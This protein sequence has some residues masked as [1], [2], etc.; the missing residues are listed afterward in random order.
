MGIHEQTAKELFG[1]DSP[2][3][4]QRSVA[5][6]VNYGLLFGGSSFPVMPIGEE[7]CAEI[8]AAFYK[9]EVPNAKK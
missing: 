2:S 7:D 8:A 6:A 1:G 5:M 9:G 4:G 3:V